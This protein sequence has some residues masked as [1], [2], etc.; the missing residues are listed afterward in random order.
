MGAER[1]ILGTAQFGL[2]YGISNDAGRVPPEEVAA[3]L[4]LARAAGV[5]GLDTAAGYGDSESVLGAMP[6]AQHFAITT[7]TVS[8]GAAKLTPEGIAE[9]EKGFHGSLARLK[10]QSVD[11]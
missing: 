6:N 3:I 5:A 10:R 9:V 11:A 2:S 7:K 1:L 8:K 4:S